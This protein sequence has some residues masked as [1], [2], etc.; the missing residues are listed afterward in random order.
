MPTRLL[1]LLVL[2]VAGSPSVAA[3]LAPGDPFPAWTLVDQ[4]GAKVSSKDLSGKTYLI[5]FYPKAMTP[6]CTTEGLGLKD[7]FPAFREKGIEILG[8]SFDA[9]S[10][11]AEFVQKQGFPFRL[12]SDSERTLAVAVGAADSP[13]DAVARRISYL[14]GPD[15]KVRKVYPKVDPGDH[16]REVL[17][18]ADASGTK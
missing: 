4:T 12:L 3:T 11:N 1:T 18:D 7:K 9:P 5:W 15:G 16:A 8:V 6:G 13:Q 2:A 17:A 14:V 10:A